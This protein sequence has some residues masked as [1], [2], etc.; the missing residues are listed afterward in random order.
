MLEALR[1]ALDKADG[2][3]VIFQKR[4]TNTSGKYLVF[5]ANI[6]HLKDMMTNVEDWFGKI[7]PEVHVYYAYSD[8]PSASRAFRDFKADK[9]ENHLKLLF[10]VDML[11]EGIHV[12]DVSGVILFRPTVS[13]IIYK[14]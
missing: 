3:D 13:P 10:T 4:I 7:D 9:S 14:Q 1:R 8:D 12:E 6:E 11:N 2:L 5:C